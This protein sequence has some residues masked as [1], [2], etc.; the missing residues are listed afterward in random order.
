MECSNLS[1]KSDAFDFLDLGRFALTITQIVELRA[2]NL[3]VTDQIHM[4]DTGGIDRESTFNTDTVGHPANRKGFADAAV[5]LGNDSA[6]ES[7]QTFAVT[8]NNLYPHTY[9][10]TDVESGEITANLLRFDGTNNFIHPRMPP[11][12]LDVRTPVPHPNG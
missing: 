10:I 8:F 6:F 5:A 4:I 3:T 9:G 7:L 1:G 11:S 12:L 2:A